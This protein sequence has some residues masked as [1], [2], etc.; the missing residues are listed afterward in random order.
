MVW[1]SKHHVPHLYSPVAISHT[2]TDGGENSTD[3]LFASMVYLF[4][5]SATAKRSAQT[6]PLSHSSGIA[7]IKVHFSYRELKIWTASSNLVLFPLK[8]E[9]FSLW[10][11][12]ISKN[13]LSW[14][15]MGA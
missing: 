5:Q 9:V 6:P 3:M 11:M 8:R 14:P 1:L 10:N 2:T 15:T 7:G 13:F 4:D 12:F